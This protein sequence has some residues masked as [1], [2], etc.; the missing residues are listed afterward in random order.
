[1]KKFI[2]GLTE[3]QKAPIENYQGGPT[4]ITAIP[5]SGK[6]R[7][8]VALAAFL[9]DK[10]GGTKSN[11]KTRLITFTTKAANEA[12][13]RLTLLCGPK[14]LNSVTNFHQL[15]S[16]IY[17]SSKP[18]YFWP[19]DCTYTANSIDKTV[20]NMLMEKYD[21]DLD[22]N[23]VNRKWSET[24][25]GIASIEEAENEFMFC[26]SE[27]SQ[28]IYEM[29]Q[30]YKKKKILPLDLLVP[31]AVS[32]LRRSSRQTCEY[33]LVDEFQDSNKSQMEFCKLLL[34]NSNNIIVAG[35]KNQSIYQWRGARPENIG[36]EFEKRYKGFSS[37]MLTK[38]FRSTPIILSA[39][40]GVLEQ[41]HEDVPQHVA[42]ST[43]CSG[44]IYFSEP[45]GMKEEASLVSR[46]I[47]KKVAEGLEY[48]D[49][50]ILYRMHSNMYE[51][52]KSLINN[53]IPYIIHKGSSFFNRMEVLDLI[54][55][56]KWAI[57]PR[58]RESAE[59]VI[60]KPR[61][62]IGKVTLGKINLNYT[63][64]SDWPKKA[65]P[66]NDFMVGLNWLIEN[67]CAE[68]DSLV[69]ELLEKTGLY[70]FYENDPDRQDSMM[71]I[72]TMAKEAKEAGLSPKE[73]LDELFLCQPADS[74]DDNAVRL[75]TMHSAKGLESKAVILIHACDA[76]ITAGDEEECN[77]V[78]V[79]VSR[80]EKELLISSPQVVYRFGTPIVTDRTCFL[81]HINKETF[82]DRL[83]IL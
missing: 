48:K 31:L 58:D 15:A 60:N 4:R 38:N 80:A 47:N 72:L 51:V 43:D 64:T 73:F 81:D 19:S 76:I 22:K 75:M 46:W 21:L 70:E 52:E 8:L 25:N 50:Y 7:T 35:D 11:P 40:K 1:M 44:K 27:E 68:P 53:R 32:L 16:R 6:T 34:G 67:L 55:Y 10:Y 82:G 5:G 49:F 66:L 2:D 61:R 56:I 12:R 39:A 59:R 62:G 36:Y 23:E 24:V 74:N 37:Y 77:L 78:Y 18:D 41:L 54:A 9:W 42:H 29:L 63:D 28:I 71:A 65:M 79:A 57:N 69:E 20:Y 17:R 13:E 3:E 33:L 14:V 83:E 45:Y 30:I 26:G